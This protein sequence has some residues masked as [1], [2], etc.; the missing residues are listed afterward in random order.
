MSSPEEALEALE[1]G[2]A[3]RTVAATAMNSESSRSHLMIQLKV[4]CKRKSSLVETR[5]KVLLCDLAGSERVKKSDVSGEMLKEAIEVNRSLTALGDVIEALTRAQKL[6]DD[7]RMAGSTGKRKAKKAG[8][9]VQIPYRNHRLTQ[10]MQD[11]LGGT[12][13]TLM[14]IA[15][16]PS[17][18]N[19]EESLM[20]LKY[21]HRAKMITNEVTRTTAVKSPA[22]PSKPPLSC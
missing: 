16:S 2:N 13:K 9:T 20:T 8:E 3:R 6:K 21:A 18:S 11:S 7:T 17:E 22:E 14:L 5:G 19:L 1:R 4:V 12:A 15:L 10:M